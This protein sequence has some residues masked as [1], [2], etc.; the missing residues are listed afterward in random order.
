MKMCTMCRKVKED[1]EY[2]QYKHTVNNK[3]YISTDSYCKDCRRLY[4]REQ[5][6]IYRERSDKK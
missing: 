4:D 5:H 3:Q 2:R 6:R 1:N